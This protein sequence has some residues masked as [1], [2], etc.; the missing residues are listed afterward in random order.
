MSRNAGRWNKG[1]TKDTDARLARAAQNMV[2]RKAWRKG[3]TKDDHPGVLAASVKMRAIRAKRHWTNKTE[4]RLTREQLLQFRLK[5]GKVSVGKAMAALGH[6]FPI[7]R[8]ECRRHDL[9]RSHTNVAE[10]F[11]METISRLLDGAKYTSEWS[12]SYFVNP[13][14]GRRFRFDGHFPDQDLL[15]EFHGR[16]HWEPVKFYESNGTAFEALQRRD[17][18]KAALVEAHPKLTL[19]TIREDE[20]WQDEQH[21]WTRLPG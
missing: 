10:H 12:S 14:T 3:L 11:V 20:P 5:N 9:P 19:L 6:S 15:V 7:V 1:L 17:K 2:G 13:E 21:L 16:Q 8:R 18:L 4:V